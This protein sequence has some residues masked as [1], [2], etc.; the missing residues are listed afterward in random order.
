M[1]SRQAQDDA[2]LCIINRFWNRVQ[3]F[4]YFRIDLEFQN[5][6]LKIFVNKWNFPN[7]PWTKIF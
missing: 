6:F 3:Y 2:M 4:Q 1:E 5:V 7:F